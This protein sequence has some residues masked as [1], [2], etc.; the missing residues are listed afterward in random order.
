MAGPVAP[1]AGAAKP[2]PAPAGSGAAKPALTPGKTVTE[3]LANNP[4][5]AKSLIARETPLFKKVNA[6][7][8]TADGAAQAKKLRMD[9]A[10]VLAGGPKASQALKGQ[11]YDC[12]V[13]Q[14]TL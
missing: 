2:P 14:S 4:A 6:L 11:W 3:M 7:P 10:I 8:A 12:L 1:G 5:Q 13:A 9:R